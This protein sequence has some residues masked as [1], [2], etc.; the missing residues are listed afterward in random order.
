MLSCCLSYDMGKGLV[1]YFYIIGNFIQLRHPNLVW[2]ELCRCQN[3]WGKLLKMAFSYF[4][5]SGETSG[6]KSVKLVMECLQHIGK[7]FTKTC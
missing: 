7:F 4:S 6:E 5:Y 1:R 2:M 3:G